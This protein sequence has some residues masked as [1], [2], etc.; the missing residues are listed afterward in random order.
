VASISDSDQSGAAADNVVTR[1][2]FPFWLAVI[3]LTGTSLVSADGELLS[4]DIILTPS[5][6][7]Y[8]PGWAVL[9]GSAVL[10]IFNGVAAPLV[11]VC[12]DAVTPGF[13]YMI[14]QRLNTPDINNPAPVTGV[15]VPHTLGVSVDISQLL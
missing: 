3:G 15:T 11:I 4:G 7:V 5:A 13:T 12:T 10:T 9:E 1:Y 2:P 8:V 14:T 6:P